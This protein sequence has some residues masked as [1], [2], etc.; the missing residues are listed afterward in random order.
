MD[1]SVRT[2]LPEAAPERAPSMTALDKILRSIRGHWKDYTASPD[3]STA[4]QARYARR[5]AHGDVI[6]I[7]GEIWKIVAVTKG[8][9]GDPVIIENGKIHRSIASLDLERVEKAAPLIRSVETPPVPPER[10]EPAVVPTGA[11]RRP[12]PTPVMVELEDEAIEKPVAKKGVSLKLRYGAVDVSEAVED[13]ARDTA[14]ESLHAEKRDAGFFAKIFKHNIAYEVSRQIAISRSRS[15]ILNE[16]NLYASDNFDRDAHRKATGAVVDR[17]L[18]EHEDFLHGEGKT[19]EKK[20]VFGD[21]PEEKAVKKDLEALVREYA[22][23]P[24]MDAEELAKRKDAIFA[25]ANKLAG[26]AKGRGLMYADNLD[27][28]AEQ[29]RQQA[30]HAG[31]IANL[32]LDLEITL[33]KA[34]L[35]A[36]TERDRNML[37]RAIDG[38][39]RY[40]TSGRIGSGILNAMH[41]EVFVALSTVYVIGGLVGRAKAGAAALATFGT[42]MLVTGAYS[43]YK[44]KSRLGR[45]RS[46]HERQMALGGETKN[47]DRAAVESE[48]LRKKAALK[49]W[50]VMERHAIDK[51]LEELKN[52]REIQPRRAEMEKFAL[53]RESAKGLAESVRGFLSADGKEL[54]G[55]ISVADATSALADIEAR[56]RI[57]DREKIDLLKYTSVAEAEVERLNLDVAR[58]SLKAALRKAHDGAFSTT[59]KKEYANFQ[60][61]YNEIYKLRE[62]ALYG[63]ESAVQK[64]HRAFARWSNWAALK[65][66]GSTM[67]IGALVGTAAHDV[68]ALGTGGGANDTT[69]GSA[70][71]ALMGYFNH[72]PAPV[73]SPNVETIG[74]GMFTT[75]AGTDLVP[76]ADGSFVLESVADHHAIASGLHIDASGHLDAASEATL[77][78]AGANIVESDTSV[79]STATTSS[80]ESTWD[81]LR[82]HFMQKIH[83]DHWM[84]NDTPMHYSDDLKRWLGADYN[85]LKLE[86]G[87]VMGPDGVHPMGLDA[88]GQIVMTMGH[89]TPDGSWHDGL[90]ENAPAEIV[91]RKVRL[92]LTMNDHSQNSV[93]ELL[94]DQHGQF[95]IDPNSDIGKTFFRIDH[96]KVIPLYHTAEV[97]ISKGFDSAGVNHFNILAT[98]QG[99]GVRSGITSTEI[100]ECVDQHV[101]N[102]DLPGNEVPPVIV[103]WFVPVRGR[104][105]MEPLKKGGRSTPGPVPPR[106]VPPVVPPRGPETSVGYGVSYGEGYGYGYGLDPETGMLRSEAYQ[107]RALRQLRDEPNLDTAGRETELVNE[108]LEQQ[109]PVYLAEL[110]AMI[111][112]EIPMSGEIQTIITIPAYSEEKNIERT[113]RQY[114][115]VQG[116]ETFEVVILENHPKTSGRDKT[117]EIIERLKREIP[118][119]HIVHLYKEFER[120]PPIGLV[121]KYLVDAVLRR[122]QKAGIDHS[123]V[124]VSNDADLEDISPKYVETITKKFHDDPKLDALAARVDYPKD[125]YKQ[126]PLFHASQRLLQ[127]MQIAFR[128]YILKSPELVGANTAFRAGTYAAVG[129]YNPRSVLGEDLEMG[130]MIKD[131]RKHDASRVQYLNAAKIVTNARRP[132]VKMLSGAN[133]MNQYAD[134]HANEEVRK[135]PL[136]TLLKERRDFKLEEFG[137]EVQMTYDYYDAKRRSKG[138]WMDDVFVDKA[139]AKAMG[140]LGVRYTISEGRVTITDA[141]GLT[142]G[143]EEY[144]DKD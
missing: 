120:K 130:W 88:N 29:V 60:E 84:G 94:S 112:S 126:F 62:G 66:G 122:R 111:T 48:L 121:R 103:P 106:G 102:I 14:E 41:E 18:I 36:R 39:Q 67:V 69:L 43:A 136:E 28:I 33:G 116:P 37:D 34:K 9:D 142:E 75:P 11:P 80:T 143:L 40:S 90:T 58:A 38:L 117:G 50:N 56:I 64:Q 27:K 85:E 31:G 42:S 109:D 35:G 47:D 70:Y 135:A 114:L 46:L 21:S 53:A 49:W 79:S 59:D 138:G 89:M 54:R 3:A 105:P 30:A 6:D 93:I 32:E 2:R 95:H 22:T 127:Y 128:N 17:F 78:S 131:A 52:G 76:Q 118:Q 57:S 124:V 81:W 44:E 96:G 61:Y 20:K 1:A 97:G 8:D 82:H 141:S 7:N 140:F 4:A 10:P 87:G 16:K 24:E 72:V 25:S 113:I 98:A 63:K 83:R 23:N 92:L 5:I 12:A 144:K 15:K 45:E 91:E 99:E 125:A 100:G 110:D 13:R 86:W 123:L 132:V 108:Y 65:R 19:A 115:K 129:G 139:F 73:G 51:E 26:E 68:W 133:L 101:T 77:R 107:E 137:A 74:G 71:H 55:D 134:F 119:L 104:Q